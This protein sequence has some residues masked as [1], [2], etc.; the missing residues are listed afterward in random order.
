MYPRITERHG[1]EATFEE[2][3]AENFPKQIKSHCKIL[4]QITISNC[5]I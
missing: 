5:I 3:M 2:I 4:A 1:T